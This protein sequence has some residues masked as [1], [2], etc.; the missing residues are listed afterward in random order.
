[1]ALWT[2][3]TEY[4]GELYITNKR[5][6]GFN[7][8]TGTFRQFL[9]RVDMITAGRAWLGNYGTVKIT[10]GGQ[11]IVSDYIHDPGTFQTRLEEEIQ[12]YKKLSRPGD[13]PDAGKAS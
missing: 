7:K 2:W 3:F 5:V 1:M 9:D 12:K 8:S 4:P 11:D 6:C 13:A 10:T